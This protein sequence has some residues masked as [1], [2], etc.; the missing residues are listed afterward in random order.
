[1]PVVDLSN[2]GLEGQQAY[3][4]RMA[5]A[6]Q[7]RVMQANA[8]QQELENQ[9]T[10]KMNELN[11]LASQKLQSILH[12]QP[13]PAV[14]PE[15]AAERMTSLA[16]PM[17]AVADVYM[18]GGGI[19]TA[20][21]LLKQAS[22]VR[23]R[24]NDMENDDVT[25]QQNKLE[26]IIKGAEIV[27]R[28]LGGAKTQDEWNLGMQEIQRSLDDGVFVMDPEL[29]EQLKSQ[30]FDP[31]AAAFFRDRAISAA[32]QARLELQRADDDRQE[33]QNAATNAD[34]AVRVQMQRARDAEV[35]RHNAVTEKASGSNGSTITPTEVEIKQARGALI[36]S[37]YKGLNT[38]DNA[39]VAEASNYVA[40]LAKSIVKDNKGL[41][42]DQAVQQAILRGQQ[43]GVFGREV[44]DN[45]STFLGMETGRKPAKR[46]PKFARTGK[47]AD[48]PMRLPITAAGKIDPSKL[49]AGKY[50]LMED[51]TVKKFSGH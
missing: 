21:D 6:A 43:A 23:K 36:N 25:A 33:R 22:E 10:Q 30:P 9:K 28:W 38:K 42:W 5:T 17:E 24:E 4:N 13:Q 8:D 35:R 49:E 14:D 29:F 31:D 7:T 48:A 51:G 50:Y 26:N 18:R 40:S 44:T 47:T 20:M 32:D 2:I 3:Y 37:V 41:T 11:D 1:M 19:E 15:A 34:R 39:D 46:D 27:S 12:R 45:V 16:E